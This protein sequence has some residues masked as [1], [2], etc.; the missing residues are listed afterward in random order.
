MNLSACFPSEK[1]FEMTFL[2]RENIAMNVTSDIIMINFITS[3]IKIL[4]D[5]SK[6]E[7]EFEL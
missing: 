2:L 4:L 1:F 7:K 6:A 3:L 5:A